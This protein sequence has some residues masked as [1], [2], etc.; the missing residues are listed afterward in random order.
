[1]AKVVNRP[2]VRM[3]SSITGTKPPK[4][5]PSSTTP[6]EDERGSEEFESL[7]GDA[8]IEAVSRLGEEQPDGSK[9]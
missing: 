6:E 4:N 3:I 2:S 8:L 9:E 7:N 5:A 1:M